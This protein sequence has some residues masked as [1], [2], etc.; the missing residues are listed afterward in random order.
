[1]EQLRFKMITIASKVC[2]HV[3][4]AIIRILIVGSEKETSYINW[5]R[6]ERRRGITFQLRI[7]CE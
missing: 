6:T 1:M 2:R 5:Q 7:N 3:N 4:S